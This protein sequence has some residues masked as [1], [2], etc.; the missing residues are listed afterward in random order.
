ATAFQSHM[1]FLAFS[2]DGKT[3]AASGGGNVI[4]QWEVATAREV[5]IPPGH[6]A[7][8]HSIAFFP[9]NRALATAGDI[10]PDNAIRIW[11][12]TTGAPLRVLKGHAAAIVCLSS[13]A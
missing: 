11:D 6:W 10:D 4:R 3:L 12:I 8:A 7:R 2:P 5:M 1:G 9:N 13:S